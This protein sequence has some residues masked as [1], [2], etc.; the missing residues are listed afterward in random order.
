MQ[1]MI[2]QYWLGAFLIVLLA[3]IIGIQ[4][5]NETIQ[6]I[7]KPLIIPVLV[8]YFLS[9][10]GSFTSNLKKWVIAA[11]F[12]SWGGDV[13][14]LFQEK[15][16]IFFLLGLASFLLAH[17]FYIFFFHLV[18]LKEAFKSNPFLYPGNGKVRRQ[19]QSLVVG[20][21]GDLLCGSHQLA[22]SFP[23]R[24]ETAGPHLRDRYQLYVHAGHAYAVDKK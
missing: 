24:Y 9:Q 13:L 6:Y 10:T 19:K 22:F 14:L 16:E 12:F 3:E 1:A 17:I 20:N 11:L 4:L 23:G 2:K 5:G 7:A 18:R 21:R 8:G 15:K